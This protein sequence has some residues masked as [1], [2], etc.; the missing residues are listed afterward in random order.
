ML[1]P[2]LPA[3]FNITADFAL[4]AGHDTYPEGSD[5]QVERVINDVIGALMRSRIIAPGFTG[6][7]ARRFQK[8]GAWLGVA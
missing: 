8:A 2:G 5:P 6:K 4:W 1:L 3:F 7:L